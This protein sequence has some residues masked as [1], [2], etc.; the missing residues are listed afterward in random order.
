MKDQIINT[1]ILCFVAHLVFFTTTQ[2]C[3][4]AKAAMDT[5]INGCD[6]ILTKL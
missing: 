4:T 5:S 6:C 2:P 3:I 1:D